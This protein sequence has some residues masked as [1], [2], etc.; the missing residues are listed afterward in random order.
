MARGDS[1][2]TGSI[3]YAKYPRKDG[4]SMGIVLEYKEGGMHHFGIIP[5]RAKVRWA[6][7]GKEIW[8][9]VWDLELAL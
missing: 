2:K 4:H 9:K 1:M 5:S 3:V 8:Y 7:T 6:S